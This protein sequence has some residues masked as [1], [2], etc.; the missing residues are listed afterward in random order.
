M[1]IYCSVI[2]LDLEEGTLMGNSLRSFNLL[3]LKT[4]IEQRNQAAITF[5]SAAAAAAAEAAEAAGEGSEEKKVLEEGIKSTTEAS[6]YSERSNR[7]TARGGGHL[8]LSV[9]NVVFSQYE[10]ENSRRPP[11]YIYDYVDES[12]E[13]DDEADLEDL[14]SLSIVDLRS[15]N[16]SYSAGSYNYQ[17]QRAATAS[18]QPLRGRGKGGQQKTKRSARSASL[19]LSEDGLSVRGQNYASFG[20]YVS[21]IREIKVQ[22][23]ARASA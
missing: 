4:I 11:Y 14:L 15:S 10:E 12:L 20:R 19:Q 17:K 23:M 8:F 1:Y 22:V 18:Q 16:I 3:R 5:D 2:P 21:V 7:T 13:A 6:S 9:K